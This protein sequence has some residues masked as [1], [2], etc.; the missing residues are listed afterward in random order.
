[1]NINNEQNIYNET[2]VRNILMASIQNLREEDSLKYSYNFI[3]QHSDLSSS[4][5]ERCAKDKLAGQLDSQKILKLS[6]YICNSEEHKKIVEY[7]A[8]LF[9][10][11][12]EILKDA[13]YEKFIAQENRLLPTELE[14][15]LQKEDTYIPFIL[16]SGPDGISREE[17]K[18]LLGKKGMDGLDY[19]HAR[20]YISLKDDKYFTESNEYSFN[21][22]STHEHFKILSNYYKRKNIGKLRNYIHVITAFLSPTGIKLWQEAKRTYHQTLREIYR[23]HTGKNLAFSCDMMDTVLDCELIDEVESSKGLHEEGN[24]KNNSSTVKL[25]S[26]LVLFVSLFF[27][28]NQNSFASEKSISVLPNSSES[29]T[30]NLE[31]VSTIKTKSGTN[32]SIDQVVDT[33]TNH[34]YYDSLNEINGL[35]LQDGS[36]INAQD[37]YSFTIMR[38]VGGDSGGG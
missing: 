37:I 36:Y 10:E 1:M 27:I 16:A 15:S 26:L 11:E 34:D 13:I 5:V 25:Q 19:L 24:M 38:M 7:F 28:N 9:L 3:A 17:V 30:A 23:N 33:D 21:F 35:Y 18:D 12:N 14:Q 31:D 4:F 20:K 8:E 6:K 2:K 29:K 32:I 22:K